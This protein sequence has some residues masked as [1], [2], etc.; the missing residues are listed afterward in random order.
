MANQFGFQ[1]PSYGLKN[2]YASFGQYGQGQDSS[3][4]LMPSM[5][6]SAQANEGFNGGQPYAA[7][8]LF[9]VGGGDGAGPKSFM[10]SD[11]MRNLAGYKD[12]DGSSFGGWGAPALGLAQGLASGYMGMKAYGLAKD[13]FNENKRQFGLNYGAQVDTTNTRMRDKATANYAATR[14]QSESP[15]DYMKRNGLKQA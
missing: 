12:A 13:T 8:S 15:D 5:Y 10:N 9:N 7:P 11:F 6:G 3:N 14:G 1:D 2:P 4:L